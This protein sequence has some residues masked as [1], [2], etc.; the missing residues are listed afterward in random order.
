ML[1]ILLKRA[2]PSKDQKR[3]GQ[4]SVTQADGRGRPFKIRS[5]TTN[6]EPIARLTHLVPAQLVKLSACGGGN[7]WTGVPRFGS[8]SSEKTSAQ[9]GF[10]LAPRIVIRD[11]Q[12]PIV[13]VNA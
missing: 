7:R 8:G 9:E 2:P 5:S 11:S 3:S 12:R 4:K 6:N 13:R 1:N 10:K